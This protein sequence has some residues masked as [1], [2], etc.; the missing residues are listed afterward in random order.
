MDLPQGAT[1]QRGAGSG[2]RKG[3]ADPASG[4][5][6][7]L[8]RR[9]EEAVGL[10]RKRRFGTDKPSLWTRL[11]ALGSTAVPLRPAL[12]RVHRRAGRGQDHRADQ[13]RAPL[14]PRRPLRRSRRVRGVGGTRDCDWWFT[15]D[16]VFLDTAGRYTTQ[17]SQKEVDA[18]AWKGFLQLLKKSRPRRPINGV[19]VTVSVADLLQQ[20]AAERDA[21]SEAMRSRVRELYEELGVRFPIYVLVTKATSSPASASS[22]RRS[23]RKSGRRSGASRCRYGQP[24][25]DAAG[26]AK[27]LERWNAGSTNGC[28]RR[29]RR[30][31]SRRAARSSTACRSSSR[32][33]ASASWTS[34]RPRSRRLSSTSPRSCAACTSRAA[35]R[36]AAPSAASWGRWPGASASSGGSC[37]RSAE[38]PE[39]LPD[40]P[41]PR[42]RLSRGGARRPRSARRTAARVDHARHHRPVARDARPRAGGLVGELPEQPGLH[43]RG[44]D[45][46]RGGPEAGGRGEGRRTEGPRRDP[47]DPQQPPD[48]R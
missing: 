21:H 39:L 42:G 4:E 23:A 19:L 47:P 37:R 30:S 12:V 6:A 45:A 20:T 43:R 33:C 34:S 26:L 8:R 13:F 2:P 16:A 11:R 1:G 15:D 46:S 14:P 32:C 38:R 35:P 27:A 22:S 44:D 5:V 18:G 28:P 48:A 3:A 25:F 9:F 7:Q 10:L 41:A 40:P 29:S 24:G 31:A 17:Q 36:R